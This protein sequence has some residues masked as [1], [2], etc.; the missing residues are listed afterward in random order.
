MLPSPPGVQYKTAMLKYAHRLMKLLSRVVWSEGMH[1][2]P[3]HFQAQS[4]YF[5]DSIH[6]ATAALWFETFGLVGLE[7]DVEA[8][9]NGTVS[10]VNARGVFPD[11]LAFHMPQSDRLADPRNIKELF[12]P[13]RDTL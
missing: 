2:G 6:F 3:H 4:R 10:L 7:L 12:P 11:G 9:S 1:L 8:L 5:E 13:T